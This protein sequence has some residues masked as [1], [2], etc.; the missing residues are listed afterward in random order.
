[1]K[2]L[3]IILLMTILFVSNTKANDILLE[4]PIDLNTKENSTLGDFFQKYIGNVDIE[5]FI[6]E[7]IKGNYVPVSLD[8]CINVALMNNFDIKIK[9]HEYKSSKYNAQYHLSKFLPNFETYSYISHY[10]GQILVGGVLSDGFDETA[11]SISLGITHNLTRGGQEIFEAKAAKYFQ[12]S[13]K[14][15]KNFTKTQTIYLTSKYYYETLL[16]KINIEIYLKNLTER[17][18]QLEL[19]KSQEKSGFGTHFDVIRAQSEALD[20][21][22]T[23]INALNDFRSAQLNLSNTMGIEINTMLMPFENEITELNLTDLEKNV[24]EFYNL[25][26][27]N[28]E[29]LK[30]NKEL[31]KYERAIKNVYVTDF[32]PKPYATFHQQFQGTV[33]TSIYPNYYLA[34]YLDWKPG[35]YLSI[36]TIKK[37]QEQKEKVKIKKLEYENKLRNIEKTITDSYTTSKFIQKQI[38]IN[39]QRVDFANESIKLAM[40]RFKYGKGILLDIIQAQGE[41]TS[42]R[43]QYAASIINYNLSQLELIYSCGTINENLIIQNY[44]P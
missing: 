20:A 31:I 30:S 28:R 27:K 38:K 8:E 19:A 44:K 29:D 3:L 5:N 21:K 39:K 41:A 15:A 36:G 1:M 24:E 26:I 35:E 32:L 6:K 17:N 9:D 34:G 37:I 12:K 10:A 23:V 40:L 43:V 33:A 42:A 7:Q 2:R 22:S 18:A 4:K 11:I 13:K 25:A 14:H 16:A